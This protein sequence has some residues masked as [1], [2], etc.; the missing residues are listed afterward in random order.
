[1]YGANCHMGDTADNTR[2]SEYVLWKKYDIFN[3]IEYSKDCGIF[4]KWPNSLPTIKMPSKHG[5]QWQWMVRVWKQP[6][7]PF[8]ESSKKE[9]E[10]RELLYQ[11]LSESHWVSRDQFL[12]SVKQWRSSGIVT[13][14]HPRPKDTG[15]YAAKGQNIMSPEGGI[16]PVA[17]G[18]GCDSDIII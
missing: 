17:R 14:S 18:Q 12:T 7:S 1:M 15:K 4:D 11:C 8:Y 13:I 10:C 3:W 5:P 9:N 6:V 2:Y 16:F